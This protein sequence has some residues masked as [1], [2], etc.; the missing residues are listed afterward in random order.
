LS[1]LI[2]CG[3]AITVEAS[4]DGKG[5]FLVSNAARV[6]LDVHGRENVFAHGLAPWLPEGKRSFSSIARRLSYAGRCELG[7]GIQPF[8]RRALNSMVDI[9]CNRKEDFNAIT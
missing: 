2:L 4:G 6:K 8:W 5:E 1:S 7:E 3:P 9:E